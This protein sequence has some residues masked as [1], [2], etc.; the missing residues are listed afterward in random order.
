MAHQAHF[1]GMDDPGRE[2]DSMDVA[3]DEVPTEVA[4]PIKG[5]TWSK[6]QKDEFNTYCTGN[7]ITS[8]PATP[9]PAL[10]ALLVR[11]DK[12]VRSDTFNYCMLC[13]TETRRVLTLVALMV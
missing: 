2:M 1:D 6:K 7:G 9:G 13:A 11:L 12:S 3:A 8:V 5:S 4:P 10:V